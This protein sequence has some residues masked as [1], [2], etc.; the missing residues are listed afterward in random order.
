MKA[1]LMVPSDQ[2]IR[3]VYIVRSKMFYVASLILLLLFLLRDF[4]YDLQFIVILQLT[5][6]LQLEETHMITH[7]ILS[8]NEARLSW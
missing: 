3:L 8:K 2:T 6:V 7:N 5:L 1:K 4:C